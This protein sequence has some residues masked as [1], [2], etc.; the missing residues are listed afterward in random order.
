MSTL[1]LPLFLQL[2]FAICKNFNVNDS[3]SNLGKDM[4]FD[5]KSQLPHWFLEK[6][7]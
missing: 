4:K 2:Y 7:G 5:P 3:C 1:T 6:V